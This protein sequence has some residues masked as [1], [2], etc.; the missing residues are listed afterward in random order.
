MNLR[1]L[2]IQ[3]K[4][5]FKKFLGLKEHRLS[6][7]AFE[8]IYIWK[9][10]FEIY[11]TRIGESLCVFFK[12]RLGCFL[13]LPPLTHSL[14]AAVIEETFVIMDGLNYNKEVSRIENIE[15]D[16]LPFY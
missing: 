14:T 4:E 1:P 6:V 16:D 8:N 2:A 11:W 5:I 9:G 15:E 7:Y 3:D 12:N 10:L 13:Y